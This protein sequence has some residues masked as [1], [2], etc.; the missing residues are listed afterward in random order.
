MSYQHV[1]NVL[2]CSRSRNAARV[3]LIVLAER[4]DAHGCS[5]P[6]LGTLMRESNVG[7]TAAHEALA[8]LVELG[9]LRIDYNAGPML[10]NIYSILLPLPESRPL[11]ESGPLPES[12]QT[13]TGK[14]T[15]PLPESGPK[16][17][18]NHQEPS[19]KE[20]ARGTLEQCRAF[21]V[22]RGLPETD[23]EA[24]FNAKEGNGW[25][26]GKNPVRDW[27]ATFRNWQD[28]NWH[29]SQKAAGLNGHVLPKPKPIGSMSAR[30]AAHQ[31]HAPLT[32]PQAMDKDF[33][34]P[35][36]AE[37]EQLLIGCIM[38]SN[39][40]V[41]DRHAD[42]I[43]AEL[44]WTT[45]PTEAFAA[46]QGLRS[47][48]QPVDPLTVTAWLRDHG[49]LD[50]AGGAAAITALT[51][52][53]SLSLADHW[54]EKLRDQLALRRLQ[55]SARWTLSQITPTANPQE[56]LA[57]VQSQ[58]ATVEPAADGCDAHA[59]PGVVAE[60]LAKL[61]RMD[62]GEVEP[63]LRTGISAW[64]AL[65]GG[66][67]PG[68]YYGLGGRPGM[69]KSAMMEQ[70]I[71]RLVAEEV[72][73]LLFEKDMSLG[74]LIERMACREAQV[75]YWRY[76]RRLTN[77]EERQQIREMVSGLGKSRLRLHNPHNLT[78][79]KLCAIVRREQRQH[80]IQAVFLDH[81][82]LLDVG[83]ELREGLTRASIAL[84][85]HI[86]ECGIPHVVLFHVNRTGAKGRPSGEDVKEF[87]QLLG[88]VDALAM[89]WSEVKREDL[90]PGQPLPVKFFA[91]KNRNGAVS[92][93][94]MLFEGELMR[95]RAP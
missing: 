53:G 72:P 18:G 30:I 49:R 50:A 28:N 39:G 44:F 81:I 22:E 78:A 17:S 35:H 74:M 4:A 6:S 61:S 16:P 68:Q 80:G 51:D 79:D 55:Q 29:P 85:R 27:K 69:G 58:L 62:Q 60:V 25:K 37:A 19:S 88:D 26:N 7:R 76:I 8:R 67:L 43:H 34:I 90:Q 10:C 73:V 48:G 41:L 54:L 40:E 45:T 71:C 59:L 42:A 46:C 70:M 31:H 84:S 92:E 47:S 14:R 56:L 66:L 94:E 1:R 20:K 5:Y 13:P 23:G 75:P 63:G 91:P 11:P 95:F 64:D 89:L 65:F 52:I 36:D 87:D 77:H 21:A 82:Q 3:M 86:P 2:E 57:E 15:K 83:K 32:N 12:E 38:M 9:E 24:F 93:E 33:H